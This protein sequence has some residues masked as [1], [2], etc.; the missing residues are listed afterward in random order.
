MTLL[1]ISLDTANQFYAWGWRASIFGALVTFFGVAFL[2]WGTHVRDQNFDAS[3]AASRERTAELQK[4]NT[5]LELRLE[6]E[7][8]SRLDMLRQLSPR[9]FSK[10]GMETLIGGLKGLKERLP[11]LTIFALAND[12]EVQSYLFSVMWALQEAGIQRQV[13]T[14]TDEI[15][16]RFGASTVGL[17]LYMGPKATPESFAVGQAVVFAFGAAGQQISWGPNTNMPDAP[18]PSL[19]VGKKQTPFQG[20]RPWVDDPLP[21]APSPAPK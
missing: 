12:D 15:F 6:Q 1:D 13:F 17:T 19:F 9:D 7:R 3:V 16:N 8:K 21:S 4:S 10:E 20:W 5:E 14:A 2:Y 11:S 18:I